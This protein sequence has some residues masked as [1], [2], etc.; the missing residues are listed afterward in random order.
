LAL[1]A[2]GYTLRAEKNQELHHVPM[3]ESA[4]TPS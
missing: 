2:S 3:R 1:G 4:F